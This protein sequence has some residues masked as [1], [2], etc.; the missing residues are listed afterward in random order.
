MLH[1]TTEHDEKYEMAFMFPLFYLKR[2]IIP[3]NM[4]CAHLQTDIDISADGGNE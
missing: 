1:V 4:L 2:I 3:S